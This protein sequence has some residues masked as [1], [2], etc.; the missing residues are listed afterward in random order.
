M[1]IIDKLVE[2]HN[3]TAIT[4]AASYKGDSLALREVG[5]ISEENAGEPLEVVVQVTEA[6]NAGGT[7][8]SFQFVSADDAA[9]TTPVVQ[10]TTGTV[11]D[12]ALGFTKRF[13]LELL[14]ADSDATHI[15]VVLVSV[16]TYSAGKVSAWIQRAG[17]GQHTIND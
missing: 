4:T 3:H 6:F 1:G 13:A 7:N 8:V 10:A 14:T 5:K 11:V 17:D 9:L 2:F 15:G 16:G 12:P